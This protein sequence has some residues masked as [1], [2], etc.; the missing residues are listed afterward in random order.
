MEMWRMKRGRWLDLLI[1][2]L[3]YGWRM[4]RRAPV[5]TLVS[6]LSLAF[7]IGANTAI[8]G[9]IHAVLLAPIGVTNPEQIAVV[10]RSD[11][12]AGSNNSFS[13][14][15]FRAL[16]NA[17]GQAHVSAFSSGGFSTLEVNDQH[18]F[19]SAEQVDGAFFDVLGLA[20]VRGRLITTA[21]E[22]SGAPVAVISEAMW[23][24]YFNRDPRAVGQ[25]ITLN[26]APFAVI[27]ILPA[28]YRGLYFPGNFELAVPMSTAGLL[29]SGSERGPG[30]RAVT[31]VA[32]LTDAAA[33]PQVERNFD[34][35]Y[36]NC[37]AAGQLSAS[38]EPR[39]ASRLQLLEISHGIPG[40]I[41][42]RA[43]NKRLL[44]ILMAGVGIV[45]LIVCANVGNLVLAR[46]SARA[47]E[48]AVRLSIGASRKRVFTQLMTESVQLALIGGA[49]GVAFASWATRAL[50]RNLPPNLY[51]AQDL[52]Q[53]G[54]QPGV[55]AFTFG[56]AL[57]SALL[58]G[59][60]PAVRATRV[61]LTTPL[62][63]AQGG[64][65]RRAGLL[66]SGIVVAQVALA[67]LLVSSAGL[68]VST[69]KNLRAVDLGFEPQGLLLAQVE[70]PLEGVA[71]A[72]LMP[73]ID[74]MTARLGALPGVQHAALAWATP[75]V[76]G[77][78]LRMN[79]RA[80]GSEPTGSAELT[81]T[82]GVGVDY[83]EAAGIARLRGRGFTTADDSASESVAIANVAF[84]KRYF[85]DRDPVGAS[86]HLQYPY[87][88]VANIGRIGGEE[89][90]VRIVGVVADARY[91][92][93]REPDGPMLYQPIGQLRGWPGRF[94]VTLRTSMDPEALGPVVRQIVSDVSPALR[95]SRAVA[96]TE[97]LD[98]A[99][100][101]ERLVAGL[102]VLFGALALA[103]AGMGL[104]GIVAFTVAQRT[105]EIGIRMALGAE[106][107][108]VLWLVGRN[109][110]VIVGLGL[111][112]G[113]P[114]AFAAARGLSAQLYGIGAHD[115]V[116]MGAAVMVLLSAAAAA[117]AWP[118][119][120]ATH[121][122]PQW[123]LR[124]E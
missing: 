82:D 51:F 25:S 5:F 60:L 103:L 74:E 113:G 124:Q 45:L 122:D 78:F 10:R 34:R 77:R 88:R 15:E 90:Q 35:A 94:V 7:G 59:V 46:S 20:P 75:I 56:A 2:D 33:L 6:A 62:K 39:V 66:D 58:F 32:R 54:P 70:A 69:L 96:M 61:D 97:V 71:Q 24:R 22:A 104:Y 28:R 105:K 76:G 121:I 23:E 19:V 31:I 21:D 13:Y 98:N 123:A 18:D 40:K 36:Q 1:Q 117:T 3:L 47:K 110:L 101:S 38:A 52:I 86:V 14:D 37:C 84:V 48:L 30:A 12:Q 81:W 92:D 49:L 112:I 41:D 80:P 63:D 118:A 4:L 89:V 111:L 73:R 106:H 11:A 102:A 100:V 85:G 42:V 107:K 17:G 57:L 79:V 87:Q 109:S 99:L 95:V 16:R 50:A 65:S 27:G 67:L 114:L 108:S 55:L 120:R 119:L 43:Q 53:M 44:M 93:P 115:P 83:F 26:G 91:Q 8:F 72:A 9:V 29:T 64:K 68:L 116:M